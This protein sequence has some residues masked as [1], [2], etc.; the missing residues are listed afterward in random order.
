MIPKVDEME[1]S[2]RCPLLV[3]GVRVTTIRVGRILLDPAVDER[4]SV[5]QVARVFRIVIRHRQLVQYHPILHLE[6]ERRRITDSDVTLPVERVN[7]FHDLFARGCPDAPH[8][9]HGRVCLTDG[10]R[11]CQKSIVIRDLTSFDT[12]RIVMKQSFVLSVRDDGFRQ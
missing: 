8:P 10:L 3:I 4:F 6:H 12:C 5:S 7:V 9:V 11:F 2:N 1:C